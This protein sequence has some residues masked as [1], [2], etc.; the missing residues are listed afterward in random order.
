M[1]YSTDE[2][3]FQ[4]EYE[5]LGQLCGIRVFEE[6]TDVEAYEGDNRR[7]YETFFK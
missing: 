2:D 3:A 6:G 7:I 5:N 4:S 1:L